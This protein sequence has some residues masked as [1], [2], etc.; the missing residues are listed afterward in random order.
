MRSTFVFTMDL[1]YFA[2]NYSRKIASNLGQVGNASWLVTGYLITESASQPMY[3]HLALYKGHKV[4]LVVA[5][6][7][8]TVGLLLWYISAEI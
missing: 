3:A 1:S 4:S 8:M 7:S 5:A 2:A 6:T